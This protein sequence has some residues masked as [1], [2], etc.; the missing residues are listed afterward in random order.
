MKQ[1]LRNQKLQNFYWQPKKFNFFQRVT[2]DCQQVLL[3]AKS[4]SLITDESLLLLRWISFTNA[5]VKKK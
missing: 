4:R 5:L 2:R 3:K 1:G